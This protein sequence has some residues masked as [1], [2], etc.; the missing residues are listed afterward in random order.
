MLVFYSIAMIL[1]LLMVLGLVVFNLS[2]LRTETVKRVEDT[3][4]SQSSDNML[5]LAKEGA[6]NISTYL[7]Q[8]SIMFTML[9]QMLFSMYDEQ[10]FAI[11]F[12]D[13]FTYPELNYCLTNNTQYGNSPVSFC[14]SVYMTLALNYSSELIDKTSR[15]DY[16][17]PTIYHLNNGISKRYFMYFDEGQFVRVFP[18]CQLPDDYNPVNEVWYHD[19]SEAKYKMTTT[20]SYKDRLGDNSTIVSLV[21]PLNDDHGRRIGAISADIPVSDIT[22]QT[23]TL[24][25]F[26]TGNIT[27]VH[28]NSEILYSGSDIF[29][30]YSDLKNINGG[31]FWQSLL[32]SDFDEVEFLIMDDVMYRVA[33]YTIGS[34]ILNTTDDW[35]YMLLLIVEESDI[36]NYEKE[37]EERIDSD[38]IVLVL[39]T[40]AST[41]TIFVLVVLLINQLAMKISKPLAGIVAFTDK[42]NADSS[43]SLEELN[44]L[45]EGE[46]QV[47]HLVQ[48]YKKLAAIIIS[49]REDKVTRRLEGSNKKVCPPNELFGNDKLGLEDLIARMKD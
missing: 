19:F 13:S 40:L 30:G 3:L 26:D 29:K 8:I 41:V 16:L 46:D 38:S 14:N 48:S 15:F 37:S 34:S 7:Y 9:N 12:I 35:W 5:A 27:V 49:K 2:F 10:S 18:G 42:M 43:V 25:Y 32:E 22:Q 23:S 4:D 33:A 39:V 28:R 24:M 47:A 1:I 6:A 20:T 17:W 45:K 31:V 36:L 44:D 21:M 11:E